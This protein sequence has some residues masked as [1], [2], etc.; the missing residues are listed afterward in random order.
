MYAIHFILT[1]FQQKRFGLF[2]SLD[3][4]M[5][6]GNVDGIV[7]FKLFLPH[8]RNHDSEII[9]SLILRKLNF[10]SPRTRY[11]DVSINN[12]KIKMIMQEKAAKE[13]LEYNKLR[14]SAIVG[15]HDEEMWKSRNL[16]NKRRLQ[17]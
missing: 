10:L 14:E 8:T 2:S 5:K 15:I 13:F 16:Y 11:V 3:V 17:G 7:K 12:K 4:H 1:G 6:T 9:S